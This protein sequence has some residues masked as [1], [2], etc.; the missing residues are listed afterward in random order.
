MILKN[1]NIGEVHNDAMNITIV[2]TTY[3]RSNLLKKALDSVIN[4]GFYQIIV[5]DDFSNDDTYS[6]VSKYIKNN[7]FL[8]IKMP[9]NSGVNVCRNKSIEYAIGDWIAFLDDDDMFTKDALNNILLNLK[10]IPENIKIAYFNSIIERDNE[11]IIGGFQ[12][13]S[14]QTFYDPSYFETMTKFNLKGD[15]KPVFRKSLFES[16]KYLFPE[17]VNGFESYLMNLIAR[18]G[19]GIRYFRD[20]TTIVNFTSN[21]SHISHTA[22]RKNPKPLLY[23]HI[24]QLDEHKEF[25]NKYP[26]ILTKKY[27]E[28]IKLCIRSGSYVSFLKFSINLLILII[29]KY[30]YDF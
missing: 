26:D 9:K 17:T 21:F 14:D 20:I 11:K 29:K 2:I 8:Y 5:I 22:P 1:L 25:Y 12:F 13:F 24:K 3:N 23:L 30:I 28:M 10:Q 6:V 19:I 27:I 18:D 7:N 15:C 4:Q 16:G